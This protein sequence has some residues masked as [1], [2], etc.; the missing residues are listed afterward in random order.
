MPGYAGDGQATC[1]GLGQQAYF[2]NSE[3]L[4]SVP[5][6]SVAYLISRVPGTFYP[7]GVSYEIWF[8]GNPG[9]FEVDIQ[10]A[11]WDLNSHYCTI[12][13]INSTSSL[14]ASFVGRVELP[15]FYARYT[16]VYIKTLT[17]SVSVWATLTR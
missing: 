11:D 9:A 5:V 15:Q 1:I 17:N 7:W 3:T 14:N 8:S 13:T 12:N 4:V 10:T 6:A 16:R 2:F